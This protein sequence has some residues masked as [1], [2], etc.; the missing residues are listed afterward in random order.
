MTDFRM[1]Q[2]VH[3]MTASFLTRHCQFRGSAHTWPSCRSQVPVDHQ[4]SSRPWSDFLELSEG[5]GISVDDRK[6]FLCIAQS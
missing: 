5:G 3:G 4:L 2:C 6:A 1:R